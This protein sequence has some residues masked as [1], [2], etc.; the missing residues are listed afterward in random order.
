M[1]RFSG[2]LAALRPFCLAIVL[3][4]IVFGQAPSSVALIA[5]PSPA[6]YGQAVTLTATVTS[7][8]TGK[9]TFYDGTAVLGIGTISGNQASMT[10]T[11]LAAGTRSLRAYYGG[12]SSFASS[13]SVNVPETVVAGTSLG[14]RHAV[15]YPAGTSTLSVAVGDLNADGKQDLGVAETNSVYIGV[16][17]G[18]WDGTYQAVVNY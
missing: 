6:G 1:R 3:Q 5:S 10:T 4:A 12:D 7:G 17:L 15:N 8:A 2:L 18:K 14:F 13:S 11:L 16:L 9:V